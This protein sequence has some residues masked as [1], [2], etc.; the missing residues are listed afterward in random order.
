MNVIY[1]HICCINNW[2]AVYAKIMCAL[3]D[4][5]LYDFID[6]IRC[7]VLGMGDKDLINNDPKVK[8][9]Y[10]DIDIGLYEFKIMQII[11]E[12]ALCE[13]F[14]ILYVHTK[15]VTR[16]WNQNVQDWVDYLIYFNIGKW[17][18]C[19]QKLND[20][21]VVG[22][23]FGMT[24][25]PHFSGNFWWSKASHIRKLGTIKDMT[26]NGPEYYITSMIDGKYHSLW[27]TGIDHY[28]EA[29]PQDRYAS[30]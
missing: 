14:N 30:A 9:K 22:V 28:E 1:F 3:H 29:Y 8:I 12:D 27:N 5:G 10:S 6:E 24:P 15:G 18:D 4:S 21:D 2:K 13:D 17:K 25:K 11:Y 16:F 7:V 23:N 20:Y 26:Y 19:M